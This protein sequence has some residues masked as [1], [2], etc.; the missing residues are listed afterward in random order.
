[1]SSSE[2]AHALVDMTCDL[3]GLAVDG[4]NEE[5]AARTAQFDKDT[6]VTLLAVMAGAAA[7]MAVT[8][9]DDPDAM[10]ALIDALRGMLHD[11]TDEEETDDARTT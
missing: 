3:I 10:P 9:L 5:F 11:L 7:Q 4:A 8:L 6:A 1:M 2:T